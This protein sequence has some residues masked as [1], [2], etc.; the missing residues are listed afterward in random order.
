MNTI[1]EPRSHEGKKSLEPEMR[2]I[3]YDKSWNNITLGKAFTF[4]NGYAFSSLD[5][6]KNGVRWVKIADVGIQEM[7]E[8]SVSFLPLELKEKH[9]KFVLKTNDY[10]I[11][12]TRPILNGKL[13]IA[14][15][16][17]AYNGALLNQRVGKLE[18]NQNQSF[19]YYLLQNSWLIDRIEKN[20]FGNEPPNL[21]INQIS[22]LSVKIPELSEQQKIADFLSSVDKKIEQLTEKH[23]LLTEYKKGVMQ[24]I[25]TQQI[26][27]KDNQGNDYPQWEE[28]N[29]G[30]ICSFLKDGT[31]G[32][33]QDEEGSKF[34]LLSA[35]NL[36]NGRLSTTDNERRISENEFH[37][38][39]QNYNLQKGDVLLSVVGTIGEVLL[40]EGHPNIAFQRSVAFFRFKN[41]VPSFMVQ[42]FQNT[43]FQRELKRRQVVSAQPGIYL[44]DLSKIILRLPSENEQQKIANFLTEI[45]Q[46]IDQAWSILEQTKAFKKGLLQ[47]MFV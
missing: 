29:I 45:D 21:S 22:G 44:G 2:F 34:F 23:S 17:E 33:H 4:L 27:F 31:H 20:I 30:A 9:E 18:T 1:V 36:K 16:N 11:A 10:V 5:S 46:K 15:I 25:F 39:Y 41:Q 7:K 32:T 38:I 19:I 47:K 43:D 12:L 8:N 24:Q 28:S 26:R 6:V 40:W 3:E 35:K 13:K 37:K 42:L 14:R